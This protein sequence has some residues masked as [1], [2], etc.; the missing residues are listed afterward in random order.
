MQIVSNIALI[1]INETLFAQLISFLIF[2]FIINRIMF[3][4]L[5]TTMTE[6]DDFIQ[7]LDQGIKDTENEVENI[8]TDLRQREKVV[9]IEAYNISAK[10]EH[11]G[12]ETAESIHRKAVS[13]I[14][15]L[16]HK[17]EKQ[18]DVQLKEAQK[19]LEAESEH[20]AV[21]IMEKVL[22]RRLSS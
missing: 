10:L 3:R 8:L 2:L 13:A 21:H 11:E 15:E 16:R 19:H 9:K 5:K 6:R 22:N 12:S 7:G 14:A 17:T 20:L 18:V 4:P 1:S